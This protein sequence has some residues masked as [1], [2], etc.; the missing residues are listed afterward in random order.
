MSHKHTHTKQTQ[1]TRAHLSS[2]LPKGALK[3]HIDDASSKGSIEHA[4]AEEVAIDRPLAS[5]TR[6][7]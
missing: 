4:E 3:L 1:S 6:H 2:A 7:L 5:L